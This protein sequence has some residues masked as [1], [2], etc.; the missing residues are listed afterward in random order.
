MGRR[1]NTGFRHGD[2]NNNN[3]D[4]GSGGAAKENLRDTIHDTA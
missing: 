3:L 2:N 1:R 4:F